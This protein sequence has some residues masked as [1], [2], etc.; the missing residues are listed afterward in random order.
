ADSETLDRLEEEDRIAFRYTDNP[1]GSARDIA[2]ILGA[3]RNV[4]GM[5][6]H[7]ERAADAALGSTDGWRLFAGLVEELQ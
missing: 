3:D 1:N 2:G 7:P 6:P 5:M 4:L